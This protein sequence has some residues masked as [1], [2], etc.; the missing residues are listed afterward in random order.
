MTTLVLDAIQALTSIQQGAD[1]RDH[2]LVIALHA[3]G[4][5]GPSPSVAVERI[6]VGFDWNAGQVI[7]KPVE[8]LTRL[9]AEQ[10]VAI[11]KSV[12]L[13][14]SWHAYQSYQKQAERIKVLEAQVA[15]LQSKVPQ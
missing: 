2:K 14:Q 4:S 11:E 9:T 15:D 6:D 3:P 12:R 1:R 5:V 8:P 10:V 13:G 7:F